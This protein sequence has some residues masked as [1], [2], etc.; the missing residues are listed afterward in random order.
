MKKLLVTLTFCFG[1][2]VVVNAQSAT[3]SGGVST[4]TQQAAAVGEGHS[5]S[6]SKAVSEDG[7]KSCKPGESKAACCSDKKGKSTAE[8]KSCCSNK[9]SSNDKQC[10]DKDKAKA[11]DKENEATPQKESQK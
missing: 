1:F 5:T 2:A 6:D 10:H 9:A 11:N 3:T 4:T 8:G 7:H